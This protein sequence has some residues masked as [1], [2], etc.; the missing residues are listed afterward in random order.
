MLPYLLVTYLRYV[1]NYSSLLSQEYVWRYVVISPCFQISFNIAVKSVLSLI[2]YQ[3]MRVHFRYIQIF[4]CGGV[5]HKCTFSLS[6][7]SSY[8]AEYIP[9]EYS[10]TEA[11]TC[12]Y[13]TLLLILRKLH[14]KILC[15]YNYFLH[16]ITCLQSSSMF[17]Q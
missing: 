5:V 15:T 4:T 11:E 7:G 13:S 3:M 16:V 1:D 17:S 10:S 8:I 6:C 12:V 2:C 9:I 14:C